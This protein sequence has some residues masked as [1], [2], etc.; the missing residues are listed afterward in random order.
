MTIAIV[1]TIVIVI[2]IM[3]MPPVPVALLIFL[4]QM[5]VIA[6]RITMNFDNPLVV[7]DPFI[8]VPAMIVAMIGIVIAV[9]TTYSKQR[10]RDDRAR[11]KT[12]SPTET[13]SHVSSFKS[14]H[15]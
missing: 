6:M 15:G 2:V 1:V 3:V 12:S 7:I 11:G 9:R 5:V 8:R 10:Q 14:K 13:R 4:R